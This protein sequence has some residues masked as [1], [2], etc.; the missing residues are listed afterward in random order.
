[1]PRYPDNNVQFER[2]AMLGLLRR[3]AALSG[4][5]P[6]ISLFTEKGRLTATLRGHES[7]DFDDFIPCDVVGSPLATKVN[8]DFLAKAIGCVRGE[9]VV[10]RYTAA[11][12]G[13]LMIDDGAAFRCI[14]MP[15]S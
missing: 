10:L 1:M 11:E 3:A 14:I 9:S 5:S 12:A 6:A 7:G 4:A 13:P 15:M 2:V 8:G